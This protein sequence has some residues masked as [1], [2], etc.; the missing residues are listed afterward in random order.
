MFPFGHGL[1]Y[2]KF[3]VSSVGV[4]AGKDGGWTVSAKVTNTGKVAGREVVQ[5]YV[6]YPM[7]KVERCVKD[8]RGFAKT[9]LLAPGESETVRIPI[10]IRDLAYFD[11]LDHRFVTDAGRY[12]LLV[13][14]SSRDIRGRKTVAVDGE[15]RF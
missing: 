6:A 14:T 13:G 11:E 2:T 7:A 12:E 8:L 5:V 4:E 1:S 10:A 3:D 9:K 15:T